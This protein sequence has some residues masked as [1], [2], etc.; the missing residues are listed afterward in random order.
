MGTPIE[1]QP[2]YGQPVAAAPYPGYPQP[3]AP[4][5][6]YPQAPGQPMPPIIPGSVAPS[7]HGKVVYEVILM[8]YS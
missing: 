6:V 5:M 8:F 7:T 4:G 3:T 1:A 2:V